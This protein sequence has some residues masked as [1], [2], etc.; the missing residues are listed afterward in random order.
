MKL[1]KKNLEMKKK[2]FD[3]PFPPFFDAE[4]FIMPMHRR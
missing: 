4:L 1:K 3:F 2:P